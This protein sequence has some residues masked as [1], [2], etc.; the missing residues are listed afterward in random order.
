MDYRF[1]ETF[2]KEWVY[3]HANDFGKLYCQLMF[4]APLIYGQIM[5]GFYDEF[6]NRIKQGSRVGEPNSTA[7][8]KNGLS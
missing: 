6:S 8:S 3:N 5:K 2:L 4:D 7:T 1:N